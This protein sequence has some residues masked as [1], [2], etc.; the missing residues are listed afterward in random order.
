M[1]LWPSV[2]NLPC[3]SYPDIVAARSIKT[4]LWASVFKIKFVLFNTCPNGQVV[5]RTCSTMQEPLDSIGFNY[6]LLDI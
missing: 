4:G 6:E 3:V 5:I 2:R 1:F